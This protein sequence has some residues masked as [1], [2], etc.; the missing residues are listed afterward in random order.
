MI[1][2]NTR[3]ALGNPKQN[4]RVN[5]YPGNHNKTHI[6]KLSAILYTNFIIKTRTNKNYPKNKA[7]LIVCPFYQEFKNRTINIYVNI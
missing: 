4:T 2:R 1:N 6:L 7:P 5:R 3:I